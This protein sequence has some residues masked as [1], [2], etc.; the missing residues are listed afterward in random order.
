MESTGIEVHREILNDRQTSGT[1]GCVN[2]RNLEP[3]FLVASQLADFCSRL[4]QFEPPSATSLHRFATS[5][6]HARCWTPRLS[7]FFP[8]LIILRAS[9]SFDTPVLQPRSIAAMRWSNEIAR[10]DPIGDFSTNI[11]LEPNLRSIEESIDQTENDPWTWKSRPVPR[12][13]P[14]IDERCDKTNVHSSNCESK[15]LNRILSSFRNVDR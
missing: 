8:V 2:D 15:F 4:Q 10:S 13:Q 6:L 11:R 9:C 7:G 12:E 1:I 14:E 5:E 3:L